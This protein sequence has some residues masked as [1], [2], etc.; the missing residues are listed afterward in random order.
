MS[1]LRKQ[2]VKVRMAVTHS[3]AKSSNIRW[4]VILHGIL[5]LPNTKRVC[6]NISIMHGDFPSNL[7]PLA[8]LANATT[9]LSSTRWISLEMQRRAVSEYVSVCSH[10][11]TCVPSTH[12]FGDW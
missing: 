9:A 2:L 3:C 6:E 10:R 1:T 5:K 11:M 4:L 7:N 12:C 8:I